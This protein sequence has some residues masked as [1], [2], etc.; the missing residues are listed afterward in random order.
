[1]WDADGREII[2]RLTKWNID[3]ADPFICLLG[4]NLIAANPG[5][6][7]YLVAIDHLYMAAG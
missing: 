5:L 1:M 3:A 2:Q 7:L 4:A 6:D